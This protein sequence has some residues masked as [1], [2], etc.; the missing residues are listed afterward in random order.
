MPKFLP[1]RCHKE[2]G[3]NQVIHKRIFRSIHDPLT[4]QRAFEG[5]RTG[6]G[7]SRDK[8]AL[9]SSSV[10][11]HRAKYRQVRRSHYYKT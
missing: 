1:F 4:C 8:M 3:I 11:S 6:R 9:S 10:I 5:R 7:L 2:D